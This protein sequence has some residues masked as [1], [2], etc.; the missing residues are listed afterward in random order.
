MSFGVL[1]LCRR[2]IHAHRVGRNYSLRS[3]V[4]RQLQNL[5]FLVNYNDE[6]CKDHIRMNSDYFNRLYVL[7]QYLGGLTSIRNVSISEQ[8]AIF[9]L[10]SHI[11]LRAAS[12]NIA[13]DVQ[14]TP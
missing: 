10:Y 8:V 4:T 3:K 11:T 7:L 9:L 5:N 1:R 13:L 6:T 12:S 14:A 2:V